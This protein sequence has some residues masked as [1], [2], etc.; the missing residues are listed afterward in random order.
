MISII[1]I[2]ISIAYAAV[3]VALGLA[4]LWLTLWGTVRIKS[5]VI[6]CDRITKNDEYI[7]AVTTITHIIGSVILI[8]LLMAGGPII[9]YEITWIVVLVYYLLS[10]LLIVPFAEACMYKK[11]SAMDFKK[12]FKF[13]FIAG[14]HSCRVGIGIVVVFW[15]LLS[16]LSGQLLFIGE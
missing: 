9:P 3:P 8:L 12:L 10:T 6:R 16:M 11:V 7:E 1:N 14:W 5:S 13:C 15:L 2:V 4:M